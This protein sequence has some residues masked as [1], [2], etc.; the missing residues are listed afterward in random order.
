MTDYLIE[1]ID[2]NPDSWENENNILKIARLFCSEHKR[3]RDELDPSKYLRDFWYE[4]T[5]SP[6][7]VNKVENWYIDVLSK[8]N[9]IYLSDIKELISRL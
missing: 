1:I 4:V 9:S 2:S 5:H 8:I 3:A 7:F 6:E